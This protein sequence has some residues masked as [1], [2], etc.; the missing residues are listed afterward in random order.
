MGKAFIAGMKCWKKEVL[1][2]GNDKFCKGL[3]SCESLQDHNTFKN[4]FCLR[5][6]IF[7]LHSIIRQNQV[8]QLR[9]H[10][11]ENVYITHMH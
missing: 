11:Y 2:M 1:G 4:T 6:D 5:L 8:V 7:Y 9:M 10:A 3:P